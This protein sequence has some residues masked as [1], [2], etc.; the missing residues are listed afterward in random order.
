VRRLRLRRAGALGPATLRRWAGNFADRALLRDFDL[1]RDFELLDLED[2]L[3]LRDVPEVLGAFG[4]LAER[5]R[6]LRVRVE[7]FRERLLLVTDLDRDVLERLDLLRDTLADLA[8]EGA[9]GVAARRRR[10]LARRFFDEDRRRLLLLFGDLPFFALRR[11]LRLRERD[12]DDS[13]SVVNASFGT[14]ERLRRRRLGALAFLRTLLERERVVERE[15]LVERVRDLLVTRDREVDTEVALATDGDL[16]VRARLLRWRFFA[17]ALLTFR[18]RD[19][20]LDDRVDREVVLA[21][22]GDLGVRARRRRARRL[23]EV[24]RFRVWRLRRRGAVD[25]EA[26]DAG[27]L[28]TEERRF[29]AERLLDFF[30]GFFTLRLF[31]EAEGDLDFRRF[32]F[33]FSWYAFF[34]AIY[35]AYCFDD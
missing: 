12:I 13:G 30:F 17:E 24:R 1:P 35:F 9:L 34:S 29:L 18:E 3:R 19:R 14:V 27:A 15:R 2:L 4:A 5:R 31:G 6:L 8:V 22:D 28:G 21:T 25:A 16:G 26:E 10:R 11:V 33:C 23:R 20:V 7:R 32:A